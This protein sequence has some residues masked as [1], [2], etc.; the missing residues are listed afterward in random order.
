[1]STIINKLSRT[2]LKAPNAHSLDSLQ[3]QNIA[4]EAITGNAPISHLAEHYAV[5]RKFVYQ[6]KETAS[7]RAR[8]AWL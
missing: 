4:I 8:D 3:R 7:A 2:I 1:M 6:Q 5:S